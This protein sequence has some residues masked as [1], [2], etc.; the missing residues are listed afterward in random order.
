ML[1]LRDHSG[2]RAKSPFCRPR[3]PRRPSRAMLNVYPEADTP[4]F[5]V[6]WASEDW[7]EIQAVTMERGR[8]LQKAPASNT[9][10]I[11]ASRSSHSMEIPL[12]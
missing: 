11:F 8:P 6:K 12:R 1:K 7:R 4:R 5:V 9:S 3:V 2:L 10:Q